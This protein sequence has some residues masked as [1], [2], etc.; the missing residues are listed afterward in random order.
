MNLTYAG[1][2]RL[3][4]NYGAGNEGFA[5][6]GKPL[7]FNPAANSLFVG[8]KDHKLAEVL[9]PAL[10]QGPLEQL[11]FAGLKQNFTDPFDGTLE[12]AGDT[13]AGVMV[14]GDA[15]VVS[16]SIFYDANNTQRVGH[17]RRPIDLSQPGP[18]VW[19]GVGDP[20]KQGF[21]AGYMAPFGDGRALTGQAG[22]PI[23]T[24]T[25]YGPN[26]WLFDP[27][28]QDLSVKPLVYYDEAHQTLGPWQG[29]NELFGATTKI[30]GVA[31]VDGQLVF[32][33]TNGVGAFGYG[34]GVSNPDDPRIGTHPLDE[35]GKPILSETFCYDPTS[36]DKGQHA[37]PYR[38]QLWVYD[39]I[40]ASDP[41]A[42]IP[43]VQVLEFPT[44]PINIYATGG[45]AWDAQSRIL[46][47]SQMQADRDGYSYRAVIHA[48]KV[49]AAGSPS[50]ELD[51]LTAEI[52]WLNQQVAFWKEQAQ[53]S[54][55]ELDAFRTKA[56]ELKQA[57]QIL[58]NF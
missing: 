16:A 43:R 54:R 50:P 7:A 2:F 1:S 41:W 24:R 33:G 34:P 18:K 49:E 4:R 45:L 5:F 25:S 8:T 13:L 6:G 38:Y 51:K 44:P 20:K 23:I 48:Y 10:G 53:T 30:S 15:L 3:P 39:K 47:M 32:L 31:S 17:Y 26:A 12:Q 35:M 40:L 21:L 29:S 57:L 28:L 9:I 37:Y 19:H 22:V 52:A 14:D 56:A 27:K 58:L 11:P 46:Y 36:D 55:L 42:N